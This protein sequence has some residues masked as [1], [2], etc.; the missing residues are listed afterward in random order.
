MATIIGGE[1]RKLRSAWVIVPLAL[2]GC[3][4]S[5]APEVGD[6]AVAP[7]SSVSGADVLARVRG[8]G[9]AVADRRFTLENDGDALRPR[10]RAGEPTTMSLAVHASPRA[11]GPLEVADVASGLSAE[12]V[13]EGALA[14]TAEEHD[15][16]LLFPSAHASG[17]HV[18]LHAGLD[19]AEDFLVFDRA[20]ERAEIRYRVTLGDRVRGLRLVERALELL[21]EGGTPRLHVSP[22]WIAGADGKFHEAQLAVE[23]CAVDRDPSAPWGRTPIAPGARTCVMTVSWAQGAVEYPAVL[24]PSWASAGTMVTG[25]RY[26]G[27]ATI[28]VGTSPKV[29]VAGGDG[30]AGS[31]SSS[32][33]YDVTTK[34]W[35]ATGSMASPASYAQIFSDGTTSSAFIVDGSTGRSYA[36]ATGTWTNFGTL[37][38]S[39]HRHAMTFIPNTTKFLVAGGGSTLAEIF[40]STTGIW[41]PAGNISADRIGALAGATPT[42]VFLVGGADASSGAAAKTMDVLDLNTGAWRLGASLVNARVDFVGGVGGGLGIALGGHTSATASTG[43]TAVS[44][45]EIFGLGGTS[46]WVSIGPGPDTFLLAGTGLPG[47]G[48]VATGGLRISGGTLTAV[49]DAWLLSTAG[50]LVTLPALTTA[51]YGHTA[52]VVNDTAVLVAGG[53][54]GWPTATAYIASAEL[55]TFD[56]LGTACSAGSTC[57]YGTCTGGFCACPTS[58]TSSCLFDGTSTGT[59]ATGKCNKYG[60]STNCSPATCVGGIARAASTC[61]GIG[62]CTVGTPTACAGHFG[63]ADGTSCATSCADDTGCVAGYWCKIAAG[64][65][66]C[67]AKGDNGAACGATHEC[68]SGFC[69]DGVCCDTACTVGC[70]ACSKALK[71]T[72]V[73]GVCEHAVADTNP[74]K[75][76]LPDSAYPASCKEDGLCDG[77]GRCR[78][79]A[80]IG[81]ACGTTSCTSGTVTG[82]TCDGAGGCSATPKDCAPY[83]CGTDAC[84]T[85][86]TAESDCA[87][88]AFCNLATGT[89]VPK[90][91]PGEKCTGLKE[92]QKGYCT[93]GYC[94]DSDCSNPCQACD[95]TGNEGKCTTITGDPHGSRPKCAGAPPCGGTCDGS[96]TSCTYK[97]VTTSCGSKCASGSETKSTCDGAGA[98]VAGSAT[99]CGAYVCSADGTS[100]LTTCNADSDCATGYG[101]G[102]D[103]K[104]SPKAGSKCSPDGTES[105][106]ADGTHKPCSPF[107]CNSGTGVC[108]PICTTSADCASGFTCNDTTKT[109]DPTGGPGGDTGSSGGCTTSGG[110]GGASA[111]LSALLVSA[112]AALGFASRKRRARGERP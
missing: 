82:K 111:P 91:A 108:N 1:M 15:G 41:T 70:D 58:P 84:K 40:D 33:L 26:H 7:P 59:G 29:L 28:T 54:T 45:M 98:C 109:C 77:S 31:L 35:A 49:S 25:R 89:C 16:W 19:A 88:T 43:G 24:D 92:C 64:V 46:G 53:A 78:Q 21:D 8:L 32:E 80:K 51:R 87:S 36:T 67:V 102:T 66:T 83:V 81:T 60:T 34:T 105:I 75:N 23:G 22:P 90:K 50:S 110:A 62:H 13:L 47:G 17:A 57:G 99:S 9:P 76:C 18:A 6:A 97:T 93:D 85:T 4:R 95:A 11:D 74:H 101:C 48:L 71:G 27:A 37:G 68:K 5:S 14:C 103:K 38:V 63:C 42:S 106:A 10:A 73:D 44:A 104:C 12:I 94:C 20:P 72:G 69:V 112:L 30:A 107:V 61:D 65:S 79:Y 2:L 3:G 96:S 39:R 56:P 86:C 100:C 55:L 52:T